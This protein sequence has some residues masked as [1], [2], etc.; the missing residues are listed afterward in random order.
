MKENEPKGVYLHL[1][2]A[3]KQIM[4]QLR[5]QGNEQAVQ[6]IGRAIMGAAGQANREYAN[7]AFSMKQ[8]M[9]HFDELLTDDFK[10]SKHT[11]K[12]TCSRGCSFCCY[13]KVDVGYF[14]AKLIYDYCKENNIVI[15]WGYLETQSHMDDLKSWKDNKMLR[16]CEFL[17]NNECSVY[18]VRPTS[19]RKH[20]SLSPPADCDVDGPTK[21]IAKPMLLNA[22]VLASG[23]WNSNIPS[24]TLSQM[25]LKVKAD[26][27][28]R[29]P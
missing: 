5:T 14:E 8:V 21:M 16:K 19:C 20:V 6:H 17:K 4:D 18:E 9:K 10:E 27:E 26:D 24:G 2:E 29:R 12:I 25:L 13:I 28:A 23:L 11:P 15:D 1:T 3:M 22:E 7:G